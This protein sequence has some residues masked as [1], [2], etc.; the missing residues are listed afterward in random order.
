MRIQ[1]KNIDNDTD[2]YFIVIVRGDF[3][4]GQ[5][6]LLVSVQLINGRVEFVDRIDFKFE[7]SRS[8]DL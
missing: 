1:W 4:F 8:L 5:S 6:I 3:M 2:R 7:L